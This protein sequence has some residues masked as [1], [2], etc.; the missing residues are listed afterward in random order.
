MTATETSPALPW[1]ARDAD[2]VLAAL[3]SDAQR[4]L[5]AAD[6]Q[7][8]LAEHGPNAIASDPPPSAHE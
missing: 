1:F 8:R 4:G 5:S 6:A 7:A 2:D 3:G